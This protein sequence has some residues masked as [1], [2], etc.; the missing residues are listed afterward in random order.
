MDSY[1]IAPVLN[2]AA[3]KDVSLPEMRIPL[4][5]GDIARA[6][7]CVPENTYFDFSSVC[8]PDSGV[9]PADRTLSAGHQ[10]ITILAMGGANAITL[11]LHDGFLDYQREQF[12]V[13]DVIE[14]TTGPMRGNEFVWPEHDI[15][16]NLLG[17]TERDPSLRSRFNGGTFVPM[18]A[19]R[20]V[21]HAA[22]VLGA[23]TIVTPE[24]TTHFNSKI[25][26]YRDAASFGY[27]VAPFAIA[28]NSREI[29]ARLAELRERVAGMGA[30]DPLFWIKFDSMAGGTGVRTYD[31]RR[32]NMTEVAGWVERAMSAC[33]MTEETAI[34][35]L[36]DL[37]VGH[38]PGVR[39]VLTNANVQGI[40]GRESAYLT[41]VT[42]QNTTKDGRYLGGTM[43]KTEEQ[44][45]YAVDAQAFAAPVL[46][47][48]W[49]QGYRGYAGVDIILCEM[50]DGTTNG[51]PIEMNG[52]INASTSLL[53]MAHWL[54]DRTGRNDVAAVNHLEFFRPMK[55][56]SEFSAGFN[57][58]LFRGEQTDH[59]GIIPIVM[60]MDPEGNISG[61]KT[62]TL[63]PTQDAMNRLENRFAERVASLQP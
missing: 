16:R 33:D 6:L 41:G 9:A 49:R 21:Q 36:I 44:K 2:A 63:A 30:R 27:D 45:R 17:L 34:P 51:F 3:S 25:R 57:D 53:A 29:E 56:F 55:T 8:P 43:P 31:P 26:V 38:L 14:V 59:T 48:A 40:C 15:S 18:Y 50:E 28:F 12:G 13:G 47:A 22:E 54:E 46:E 58:L 11:G 20:S 62:I 42:F 10:G 52:R 37:D 60:K 32:H 24:Q 61:V 1:A 4:G 39:R 5:G 19:T 23:S 7:G 35:F